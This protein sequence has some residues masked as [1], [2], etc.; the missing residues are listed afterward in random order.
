MRA[1]SYL[2]A[3]GVEFDSVNIAEDEAAFQ[4]LHDRGIFTMP[5]VGSGDRYVSGADITKVD[6]L[7]GFAKDTV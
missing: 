7:L 5:V 1:K 3:R 6:E 2:T 4:R